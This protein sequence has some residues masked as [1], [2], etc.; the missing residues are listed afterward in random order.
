MYVLLDDIAQSF[1]DFKSKA[2]LFQSFDFEFYVYKLRFLCQ[3]LV[4]TP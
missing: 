3:H 1:L 2:A 4:W